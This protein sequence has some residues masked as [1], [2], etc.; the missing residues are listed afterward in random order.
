[1]TRSQ[2]PVYV[3][4]GLSALVN[5]I[6]VRG[7]YRLETLP[8]SVLPPKKPDPIVFDLKP[9]AKKQTYLDTPEQSR[10]PLRKTD[11]ISDKS[12]RADSAR[13]GDETGV[14]PEAEIRDLEV[15]AERR[16]KTP[17]MPPARLKREIERR[18]EKIEKQIER[19]RAKE[20]LEN[21]LSVF[22][23]K[24]AEQVEET[25]EKKEPK[26][27]SPES[28]L[29]K[30]RKTDVSLTPSEASEDDLFPLPMISIGS[31]SRSEKG[32][33]AFDAR[34]NELGKYIKT[35]REKIGLRF[36]EM[37]FFHYRSSYIFESKVR[38]QFLIHPDGSVEFLKKEFVK[39][40]PLFADYCE[41]VIRRAAPFAP[42]SPELEP[43]LEKDGNLFMNILFGYN[44]SR[45]AE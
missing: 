14:L 37:V 25:R 13:A 7:L 17:L 45:T 43:F 34:G 4:L 28:L 8:A 29:E 3:A 39:G 42:L 6:G 11:F 31:R 22:E 15:Q 26:K 5:F 21:R 32:V 19:K 2:K 38:M 41:S 1:M 36:H 35:M 18:T 27:E 20:K 23:K 44:V 33:D 30:I 9:P 10:E 16:A 40:D 12:S 24:P